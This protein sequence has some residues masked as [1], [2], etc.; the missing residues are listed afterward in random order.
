MRVAVVQKETCQPKKCHLECISVCPINRAGDKCIWIGENGKSNISEDLCIDCGLCIKACPFHA[1]EIV[2]TPEQLKEKP[3]QRFGV[4]SFALFRLPYPMKGE[5]VGLLGPNGMGKTTALRILTGEIKPN[6]GTEQEVDKKELIKMF[7][8]TELQSYLE[9]LGSG[10]VKT[11]MKPQNIEFL[12]GVKDTVEDILEKYNETGRR[13]FVEEF[14]GLKELLSRNPAQ[15]SGGELQRL[16]IAVAAERKAD[17]YY[18]DEPSSYLD[19]YQRLQMAKLLRE[20]AKTA[21]VLV[22][23]HDL[24]TLDMV[25]DRIHIFYGV[26]AVYGIVS[27]PYSVRVGIN[28]FLDG[29][30]KDENMRF[31]PEALN[32]AIQR[33]APSFKQI[34]ILEWTNLKLKQGSFSLGVGAGKLLKGEVVGVFGANGL[35]KT[36]FARALAGELE[37]EG[38]ISSTEKI[39]YKPQYLSAGSGT[40]EELLSTAT[41]PYGEE[42]RSQLMAPLGLEWLMQR[43]VKTLSGGE[44]QRVAIALCLSR[45]TKL[46]LL[47]EPSAFLDS[48]QRIAVAKIIRKV[49]EV[50]EASAL[51]IDHDLLFL[52]Y[53]ADSGILFTGKQGKEGK[54]EPIALSEGLNKFLQQ[55]GVSF[56]KDPQ[57]GRPRAN[58]PGSQL[59][60][61]QRSSGKYF[62]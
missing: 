38:A 4:N 56:R 60:Q 40:V 5:V 15:L 14:L 46:F 36:T 61:E 8:G 59:D 13:S 55:V 27:V 17:V 42:F 43:E 48:E 30:L 45:D 11:V 16:A 21:A 6:F 53:L 23:E 34:P 12:S 20:L 10:K 41:N 32:F 7:R 25:A 26:P 19:V 9:N 54:A 28:A 50:R 62:L 49:C 35:G 51:V 39:S 29:Y 37:A 44:L 3:L 31:R 1:I 47:D 22:V 33:S 52:S 24:A 57:T 2:R 18:F 58:K